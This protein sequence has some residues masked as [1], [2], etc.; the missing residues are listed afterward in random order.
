[1][2]SAGKLRQ[3]C[4]LLVV[5]HAPHARRRRPT[6]KRTPPPFL[7]SARD[8]AAATFSSWLDIARWPRALRRAGL[9]RVRRPPQAAALALHPFSRSASHI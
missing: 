3:R 6:L 7:G 4:Q 9:A 1:V 2:R 8:S 5:P